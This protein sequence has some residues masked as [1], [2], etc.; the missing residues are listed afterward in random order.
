M[1]FCLTL[2]GVVYV[3]GQSLGIGYEHVHLVIV[4]LVLQL[5]PATEAAHI[6]SYVQT[7]RRSVAGENNPFFRF[8]RFFHWFHSTPAVGPMGNSIFTHKQS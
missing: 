7:S 4:A 2:L 5:H 8:H 3:V 6:V 1:T